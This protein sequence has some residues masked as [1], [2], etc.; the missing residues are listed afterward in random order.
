MR[1]TLSH[2]GE[3]RAA[4]ALIVNAEST[5]AH[6]H[7]THNERSRQDCRLPPGEFRDAP[8]GKLVVA[9]IFTSRVAFDVK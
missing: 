7:V 1:R 4:A 5:D 3:G 9:A 6:I 8:E 2:L